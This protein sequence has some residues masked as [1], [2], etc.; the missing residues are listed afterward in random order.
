VRFAERPQP[1]YR[2]A[3][4]QVGRRRINGD[5]VIKQENTSQL[6]EGVWPEEEG[7]REKTHFNENFRKG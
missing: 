3:A 6:Y 1:V 2:P 5:V 4:S 7:I